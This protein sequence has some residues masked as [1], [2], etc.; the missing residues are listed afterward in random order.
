MTTGVAAP[1]ALDPQ[2][3]VLAFSNETFY[4]YQV[5]A[6]GHLSFHQ[7]THRED[8][9]Y[10]RHCFVMVRM[11]LQFHRFAQFRPDLPKVSGAEYRDRILRLARIPAWSDGTRPRVQFPGYADLRSFSS[12]HPLLLQK[13]MG[14]WWP[15]FWRIGNW[16]IVFPVPRSGQDRLARFLKHQ[17]D[18]GHAKAV[19]I[20]RF[21]PI[22]HCLIV[23]DYKGERNG[24]VTYSV[25]DCNQPNARPVLRYHAAE[26][27]FDFP[28][29]W[30][31]PGGRVNALKLYVS[32]LM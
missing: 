26:R 7:R 23:Y 29:T 20:T 24:D 1:P 22:N 10:S 32:P 27:S 30:Y 19:Y 28:R 5:D 25:Y 8:D 4:E 17:V 14:L 18:S 31:W 12:D 13:N 11:V 2:K 6:G 16:R 9:L 15:S 21:R 3:D